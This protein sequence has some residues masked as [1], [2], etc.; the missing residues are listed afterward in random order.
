MEKLF[1]KR[2][3]LAGTLLLIMLGFHACKKE[4]PEPTVT[5]QNPYTQDN[6][7]GNGIGSTG[8]AMFWTATTQYGQI[9]VEVTGTAGAYIMKASTS[10]T[11]ACGTSGYANFTLAPGS[12]SWTALAPGVNWNGTI[13]VTEGGCVR[14]QLY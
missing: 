8:Q 12:Y 9:Y 2:I 11:P 6:G 13:V 5:Y 14:R 4:V 10:G 7:G 1:R 3:F